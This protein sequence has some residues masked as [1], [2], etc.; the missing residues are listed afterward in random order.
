MT[1]VGRLGGLALAAVFAFGG[2]GSGAPPASSST[3]QATVKGKVT[4]KG[5]PLA[6]VEVRF[7]PANINRKTAAVVTATTGDDGAYT[8]STLVDENIITLGGA[9]A[10]SN[11][12]IN[13]FMLKVDV[14]PGENTVDLPVP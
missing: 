4:Y 10:T 5:N 1:Q 13:Y 9:V 11:P 6:K 7:N 14:K 12:T 2:C 8:I 3:E